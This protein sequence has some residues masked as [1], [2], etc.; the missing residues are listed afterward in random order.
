MAKAKKLSVSVGCEPSQM[1]RNLKGATRQASEK[2]L[3]VEGHRAMS[4]EACAAAQQ[5]GGEDGRRGRGVAEEE[6]LALARRGRRVASG[7]G[8]ER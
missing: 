7:A 1:L 4:G 6:A 5:C 3:G 2:S 8:A